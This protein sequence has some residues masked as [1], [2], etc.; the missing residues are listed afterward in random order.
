MELKEEDPLYSNVK[1]R[2]SPSSNSAEAQ[3]YPH[4]LQPFIIKLI[5]ACFLP[6]IVQVKFFDLQSG[7]WS[8]PEIFP[9]IILEKKTVIGNTDVFHVGIS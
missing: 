5:S 8:K 2:E 1:A 4:S 3:L 9:E 7:P 6:K